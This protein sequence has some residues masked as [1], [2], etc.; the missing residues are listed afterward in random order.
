MYSITSHYL[1]VP[2]EHPLYTYMNWH[3]YNN[4]ININVFVK[5]VINS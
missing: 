5:Q 4:R 3:Y 1:S 2:D